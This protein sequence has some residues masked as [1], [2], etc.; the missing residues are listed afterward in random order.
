MGAIKRPRSNNWRRDQAINS[1]ET[2]INPLGRQR[3]ITFRIR[4]NEMNENPTKP[5]T[6]ATK[7]EPSNSI[8]T[9]LSPA[10][11]AVNRIGGVMKRISQT[12][13]AIC[14]LMLSASVSQA[15][16][17]Q[18]IS[19]ESSVVGGD[20]SKT[21]TTVQFGNDPLNRFLISRVVKPVPNQAVRGVILLLPPLGSGF[22]NYEVG[23]NGDYNNS[24]V[25][26]FARRNFDVWGYS[27]RVQGLTAGTCES[28]AADCSAMA[29]WGLQTIVEDV[30]FIRQQIELAHPGRKPVVGGLSLGSIAS[31]ATINAH[32]GDYAGAMLIDG[33]IYDEDPV[34]RAINANFCAAMDNLLANG[35]F[36]DGQGGPGFKFLSFLASVDPNG[37]TPLPGFPP[38]F[39]NHRAFVAAMTAPPLSP[40]TPRPGF[41]NLAGSVGEDRFFFA[42]ESLVHANIAQFVDY[43]AIRTLRDLTCG[44][45]GDQTFTGNLQNFAGPVIMFAAGHGFGTGMIDTA[46]LMTSAKVTL[47]FNEVYGHVDYVFSTNHLHE[48]EHP[49]FSWLLQE[50][51]KQP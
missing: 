33:T 6:G 51:F 12:L 16:P 17:Y 38:G 13:F 44:L 5:L 21:V 32:P 11:A 9:S 8:T 35:I 27:Q 23:E 7:P 39:T 43:T 29:G 22:Q 15:Q 49:I 34:V 18:I 28:G 25:A 20:L 47:N 19:T 26:F 42:N 48:V 2:L 37:L 24:F 1:R 3:Q 50:A 36:Y 46:Q 30:A 31:L 40:L 4:R 41:Y 10:K 45:A 14:L